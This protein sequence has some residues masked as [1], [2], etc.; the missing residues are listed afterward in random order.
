MRA[1]MRRSPTNSKSAFHGAQQC[2][3]RE[4]ADLCGGDGIARHLH[5]AGHR[6]PPR[7]SAKAC[8]KFNDRIGDVVTEWE[9][10]GRPRRRR[11]VRRVRRAHRAIPGIPPRAGASAAP[12]S[13][14]PPARE[15]GDNDAN[16]NVRTALNKDLER[17]RSSTPIAPSSSTREIEQRHRQHRL[18]MTHPRRVRG[19]ACRRRRADDLARLHRSRWPTSPGHRSGRRR[20][21]TSTSPIATARDEIGALPRSI[22]VFQDA[23]RAQRRAQQDGAPRRRGARAAPGD[24]RRREIAQF[25]ADVEATLSRTWPHCPTRCWQG[26]QQLAEAPP[27]TLASR[28]A[29]AATASSEASSQCARHRL[30]GRRACRRRCMEIDRQVAQSNAIADEGGG[31]GRRRPTRRCRSSTRPP[32]ASATWSSSS[33]TSPSRPICWRSTPPSRRRAPAKP[34]AALRWWRAR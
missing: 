23:M 12:R 17:S 22:A 13:A 18:W 7:N 11:P 32:A 3:A 15:W 2:R 27:T 26:S 30:R 14:R 8:S 10:R 1:S 16:R 21:A 31:G 9:Q 33:P 25:S 28:T 20:P 5:V 4:C 29:R 24:S 34:A 19:P 6:R